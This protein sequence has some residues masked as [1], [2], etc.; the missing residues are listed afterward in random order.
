MTQISNVSDL[1]SNRAGWNYRWNVPS[2]RTSHGPS[3]CTSNGQ[4]FMC[5]KGNPGDTA[6][7]YSYS[8][9]GAQG[10]WSAQQSISASPYGQ[11]S[12]GTS[13]GPA[14]ATFFG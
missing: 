7:W 4:L 12:D 9:A 11:L 3:L 8:P 14:L 10:S 13:V 5:W 6:I 2:V 1:A